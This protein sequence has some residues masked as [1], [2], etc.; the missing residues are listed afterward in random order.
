M[1]VRLKARDVTRELADRA[2]IEGLVRRAFP[3]SEQQPMDTLLDV[4]QQDGVDF[5]AYYDGG[6]FCGMTYTM[7]GADMVF[8]LYLAVSDE[9]RSRGY[10]TAI[11]DELKDRFA[12]KPIS[13]NIEPPDP[14]ADNSAQRQRRLEFYKRNGFRETGFYV[15][16]KDDRYSIL[17]TA[18]DF[19]V[20]AYRSAVRG[21]RALR[22]G[23]WEG[24]QGPAG[25]GSSVAVRG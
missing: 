16:D 25:A 13:L 1:A 8:V 24:Q 3:P 18:E 4:A 23:A 6:T 7:Q 11:L 5:Q 17:S 20:D 12:G 15:E 21:G 9:I 10:G 22:I 14:N 2:Q 19:A